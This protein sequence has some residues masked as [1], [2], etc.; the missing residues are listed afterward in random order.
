[1]T[2]KTKDAKPGMELTKILQLNT[3]VTFYAFILP[4]I[5]LRLHRQPSSTHKIANGIEMVNVS[6]YI[7]FICD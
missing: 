2:I 6:M 3:D 4:A 5:A 1:M 7:L